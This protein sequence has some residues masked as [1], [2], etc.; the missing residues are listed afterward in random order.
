M[1]S[2]FIGGNVLTM[3]DKNNRAKAVAVD[4]GKIAVIGDSEEI[5]RLADP[6][7]T[8]VQLAGRTLIPG[9]IDTHNH[10]SITTFSPG[11]V[12]CRIPPH[13]SIPGVLKSIE[14]AA[15]GTPMGRWLQGFGFSS[16]AVKEGRGMT[17]W[18]LDEAAPNNPV[19]ILDSSV[20]ACFANS[21]ALAL[22]GIDRDTP[23]SPGGQ[24]LR[25]TDGEPNG[26]LWE[27]AMNPVFSLSIGAYLNYYGDSVTDLVQANCMRHLSF[28]ITSVGDALVTPEA[29]NMY[30]RA[31]KDKKLPLA[32][33]QMI[34]GDRFY[35]PPEALAAGKISDG[36]VSDRLRGGTIKLFVDPV[37]PSYA[38]FRY[39]PSGAIEPV[40][41]PNYTQ[42]ELDRLVTAA[43]RRGL[44]VALHCIGT[45]AIE[46]GLN[47]F[48]NAQRLHPRENPRF[49]IEH[50]TL[51]TLS[52]IARA[53]SL[54]VLVCSQP[55]FVF[56]YGDRYLQVA[57]D[58]GGNIRSL[59]FQT[60]L[61]AGV[62]IA[63]SADSPCT[64]VEPLLGLYAATTRLPRS[65]GPPTTPEESVSPMDG[66]R[67]YTIDAA[68]A[69]GRDQE[70][71]SLETGKRAD[72]VVLSN[73]PTE[74]DP[75][76]IRDIAVEQTYVDGKCLYQR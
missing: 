49:R 23:D 17:R 8:I 65:G 50:F 75:V 58:M 38:M 9:F 29:G 13:H 70:T 53:G 27:S 62:R 12:D 33:H 22:A 59:P 67:M 26:T 42:A 25:D 6:G 48:E 31:D 64:P 63:A 44:Q 68:H 28:G 37:F 52:Q 3:D 19:C 74:V 30:R 51:P 73:D 69:M 20:H 71:G 61:S 76:F 41:E 4:N 7:T 14:A 57:E 24:I 15:T 5:A 43:H 1:E 32:I 16:R 56:A 60:M 72:M 45:R 40:G 34:G 55:S 18:E 36:Q 47:T 54:G 11:Y 2:I 35:D 10:F 21:S 66:L 39:T 46:M